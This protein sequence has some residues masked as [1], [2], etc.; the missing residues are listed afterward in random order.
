MLRKYLNSEIVIVDLEEKV[1]IDSVLDLVVQ[2]E[3]L[4]DRYILL[5]KIKRENLFELIPFGNLTLQTPTKTQQVDEDLIYDYRET[6]INNDP[7]GKYSGTKL[8]EIF[9]KNDIG[10][11]NNCIKNMKNTYIKD[12]VNYLAKY[13]K[14]V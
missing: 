13:Y 9:D 8:G 2:T 7:F 4:S 14:V 6:I 11:V 3:K 10:W 12:R 1:D 5:E